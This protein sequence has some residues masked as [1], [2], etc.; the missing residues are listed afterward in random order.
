M[1]TIHCV[2]YI[3]FGAN[4]RRAHEIYAS[5]TYQRVGLWLA[6]AGVC[7]CVLCSCAVWNDEKITPKNNIPYRIII[8]IVIDD[9]TAM[10]YYAYF[11]HYR[12]AARDEYA[13]A[14]IPTVIILLVVVFYI[15][16]I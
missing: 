2:V 12:R 6:I 14:Q 1:Y 9:C 11:N 10:Q 13:Y 16:I 7:V 3:P 5:C 15:I 8:L 4:A